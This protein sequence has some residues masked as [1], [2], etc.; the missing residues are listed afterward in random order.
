MIDRRPA[1]VFGNWTGDGQM[2]AYPEAAGEAA[3]ARRTP[4]ANLP[5]RSLKE[6]RIPALAEA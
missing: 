2:L 4:S 6:F 3:T 5:M 1:A